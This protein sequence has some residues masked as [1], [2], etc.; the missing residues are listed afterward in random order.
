MSTVYTKIFPHLN[1]NYDFT[2]CIICMASNDEDNKD[3]KLTDEH[4][5]PEF[6]GGQIVVKNVCKECNSTLGH[7]LEGPLAKNIYFKLYAYTNEIKGKKNKLTN[8]LAGEYS[9]KGIRFRYESDFSLYQLP[10]IDQQLTDDGAFTFKASI[11]KRDLKTIENDIFKAISRKAK[12]EGRVLREDKLRDDIKKILEDSKDNIK[13]LEQPEINISFS[14]DYDLMAL[15]ALKIVYEL[16]AWLWGEEFISAN[17]FNFMRLSLKGLKLHRK[18]KYINKDFYEI[19]R[20]LLKENPYTSLKDTS[21]IDNI[22]GQ[23]KTIVVFMGG[24]CSIRI[25]NIWFNFLMPKALKNAFLIFTSDSRTG[26]FN[27]YREEIFL[28]HR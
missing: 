17:Q 24:G 23:N 8:P 3:K 1:F 21:Y 18:L 4:I 14:L 16:I 20:Q 9:Y 26:D 10:V 6:I 13:V 5:V 27:F 25:L 15:L 28:N 11:D 12:K 7:L 2:K 19:L 22:F